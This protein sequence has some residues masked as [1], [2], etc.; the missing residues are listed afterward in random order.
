MA[1][2]TSNLRQLNQ[3]MSRWHARLRLQQSIDWLPRGLAAGLFLSLLLAVASRFWPLLDTAAIV[4][5]SVLLAVAGVLAALLTVWLW[6]RAPIKLA[7]RFDLSFGLKERLS[8]AVELAQGMLRSES[9]QIVTHQFEDALQSARLV[10]PAQGMPFQANWREWGV[11]PLLVL[12][13]GLAA[14]LPNPQDDVLRQRSEV[15]EAIA[16]E[17]E[18]L[19][20]IRQ[21]VL[22]DSTLT[23]EEQAA[24]IETL[25]EA[26]ETLEQGGVTQ[27][28]GVAALDAAE[29]E[30]RDLSAQFA[31]QR[32]EALAQASGQFNGTALDDV[33]EALAEENP[34]AAA[35]ALSNLDLS[36][37]SDE[38][39]ADLASSL[40]SAADALADSNPDLAE[41]LANAAEAI[42]SGDTEAAQEALDQAAGDLAEAGSGSTQEVDDLADQVSEGQGDLA[43]AGKNQAPQP[44]QGGMGQVQPGEG[45]PDGQPDV[46]P[47]SGGAGRGEFEGETQGGQAGEQ[48]PTDNGPGDGGE[49][50]YDDIYDPQRVGGEGGE[51]VDIPGDPGA[52]MPTGV[53]G[54]F[55]ENPAGE[56]SVPYNQ[57]YGDYEGAVNEALESG[58]VP[59]GLRDVIRQYFSRLEPEN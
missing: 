42:E 58:Y 11:I 13:L 59:L 2:Q 34:L 18:E 7:R 40:Q 30:L 1:L 25:D 22:E 23:A 4:I 38:E 57:V 24:L 17:L 9:P 19:E 27:E 36:T 12:A 44:G 33:A 10:N 43:D 15:K 3:A 6:R 26:I 54:N 46:G 45:Q 37:L 16:Q 55:A 28:E 35:E 21:D 41:S 5:T 48:M 56:S 47:G 50:P 51:Q 52:G 29:Q 49:V 31:A 20:T 53:E 14:W 39:L 8:T 32:Q